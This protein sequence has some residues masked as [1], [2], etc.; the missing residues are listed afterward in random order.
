MVKIELNRV[1]GYTIRINT[2]YY[3]TTDSV[4]NLGLLKND[5][6]WGSRRGAVGN[7]SDWEP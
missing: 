2:C 7:E 5:F 6:M 3:T 1:S 4:V